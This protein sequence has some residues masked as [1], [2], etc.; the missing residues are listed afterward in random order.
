MSNA[1]PQDRKRDRPTLD[2][3][4]KRKK[5]R[6]AD[7]NAGNGDDAKK[8]SQPMPLENDRKFLLNRRRLE[9]LLRSGPLHVVARDMGEEGSHDVEG[10]A[11]EEEE[12]GNDAECGFLRSGPEVGCLR[13]VAGNGDRDGSG[14]GLSGVEEEQVR[15]G[16]GKGEEGGDVRR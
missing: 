11:R 4:L 16:G 14:T 7:D 8:P 1:E 9:I 15:S 3:P 12:G 2:A 10:E 5:R 13:T 6:R